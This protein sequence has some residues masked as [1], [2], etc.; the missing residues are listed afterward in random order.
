MPRRRAVSGCRAISLARFRRAR[1]GEQF[2][3]AYGCRP[4]NAQRCI[5]LASRCSRISG[6]ACIFRFPPAELAPKPASAMIQ[7]SARRD[8]ELIFSAKMA[9]PFVRQIDPAC[10]NRQNSALRKGFESSAIGL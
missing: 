10:R 9:I 2:G 6:R 3:Y 7:P 4:I 1:A 5:F 8:S